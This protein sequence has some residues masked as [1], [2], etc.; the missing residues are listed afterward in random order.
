MRPQYTVWQ[1]ALEEAELQAEERGREAL[2]SIQALERQR[3]EATAAAST[4]SQA[5]ADAASERFRMA[6]EVADA[7][8]RVEGLEQELEDVRYQLAQK[9]KASEDASG[10]RDH[11]RHS[12]SDERLKI[13][14]ATLRVSMRERAWATVRSHRTCVQR[15]M[16]VRLC[17]CMR[18]LMHVVARACICL[19][20]SAQMELELRRAYEVV[21]G[22]AADREAALA[23]EA[24]AQRVELAERLELI[25]RLRS[26]AAQTQAAHLDV[27]EALARAR[28]LASTREHELQL[29]LQSL[30]TAAAASAAALDALGVRASEAERRETEARVRL[31]EAAAELR[32]ASESAGALEGAEAQADDL[33]ERLRQA[34]EELAIEHGATQVWQE[35]L[36]SVQQRSADERAQLQDSLAQVSI[37]HQCVLR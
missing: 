3:D 34:E 27:Q 28:F 13:A 29:E 4:T 10:E 2:E 36:R 21:G 6:K 18:Q 5:D 22:A 31:A 12:L 11:L 20:L 26:E 19:C 35:E 30:K 17:A 14:Q 8:G 23:A 7:R 32:Q 37:L 33:R 25:D 1:A 9:T 15:F 16:R 24:A